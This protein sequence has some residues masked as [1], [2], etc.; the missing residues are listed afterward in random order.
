MAASAPIN[1]SEALQVMVSAY[2][3]SS[4]H[5]NGQALLI[6]NLRYSDLEVLSLRVRSFS[7]SACFTEFEY[8]EMITHGRRKACLGVWVTT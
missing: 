4:K 2:Y 1:L 8:H 3:I 7:H 5:Q 6:Q